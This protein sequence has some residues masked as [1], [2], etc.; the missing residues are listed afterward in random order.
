MKRRAILIEASDVRGQRDLPGARVDVENLDRFIT[1]PAGGAWYPN[2]IKTLRKP[3]LTELKAEIKKA[4]LEAEYLFI[5]FAGHGFM[6]KPKPGAFPLPSVKES[7]YICLND[8]QDVSLIHVNPTI[9]N[10]VL[11]DS[12]REYPE[13]EKAQKFEHLARFLKED[14]RDI[15]RQIFDNAV[16]TAGSGQILAFS[17]GIN[18]SAE[19]DPNRGGYFTAGM[20]ECAQSFSKSG[21]QRAICT[22]EVFNCAIKKVKILNAQQNPDYIPGRRINN[23]FPFAVRG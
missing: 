8:A 15:A 7:T 19:D 3:S 18:E 6:K 9:K 17:C 13:L 1:S 12:C 14:L 5:S 2:E 4:E 20:I 11:I 16:R 21:T 23:H 10:F 22:D